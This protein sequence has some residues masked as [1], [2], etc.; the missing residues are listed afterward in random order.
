MQDK[1]LKM[2]YNGDCNS[3]IGN[4]GIIESGSISGSRG[5]QS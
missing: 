3:G 5:N 4:I 2:V 1:V